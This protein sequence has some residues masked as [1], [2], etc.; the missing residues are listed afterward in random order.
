M[1]RKVRLAMA[2]GTVMGTE[3]ICAP[4]ISPAFQPKPLALPYRRIM[5]GG[6]ALGDE[7]HC[8]QGSLAVRGRAYHKDLPR[9]EERSPHDSFVPGLLRKLLTI[10][11]S[12]S[13]A[14]SRG[15]VGLSVASL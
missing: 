12:H 3:T 11:A 1:V 5:A 9:D 15:L 2:S 14:R 7:W 8:R 10:S 4:M 13:T 6:A